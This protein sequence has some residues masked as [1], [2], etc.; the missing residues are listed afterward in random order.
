MVHE[1]K[2]RSSLLA[3]AAVAA[4]A[5][6]GEVVVV[7]PEDVVA[8]PEDTTAPPEDTTAPPEDTTAPPDVTSE[9]CID[10][11]ALS[12]FAHP[13]RD[14]NSLLPTEREG[15]IAIGAP[16]DGGVVELDDSGNVV[17]SAVP[18]AGGFLKAG[19]RTGDGGLVVV[20]QQWDTSSPSGQGLWLGRLDGAGALRAAHSLGPTHFM[21]HAD[22]ELLQHPNGG[23]VLS[24]HDSQMDGESPRLVL[25]RLDD[26]GQLV[27]RRATPLAPGSAIAAGWSRGSAAL[28][29][30][31]DVVQL[32]AHGAYL[33]IV[34]S[35]EQTEPVFD[36]VLE[37]VG[38][39]WPQDIAVLPDG[40]MAIVALSHDSLDRSHVILLDAGG[41]VLWHETYEP[42]L[43]NQ[44][45]ALAYDPSTDLL[46]LAGATRGTD[47][48][49]QRMWLLSVTTEGAL[50]WEYEGDVGTPTLM[51]TIAALPGGGFAAAGFGDFSYVVVRPD[52][53]P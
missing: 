53:C 11:V 12:L 48:G 7:P 39:A 10:G 35:T 26:D 32:T 4:L 51:N 16:D 44:L 6:C 2:V 43:D 52:A 9:A 36:R 5:G 24:T 23:Y 40:R 41:S 45:N 50:R 20:G 27:H 18:L 33:R 25:L 29:P 47:G 13:G 22:I 14:V 38:E 28:L 3:F 34:R 15:F 21:A 1:G 17:W 8:P 49:T 37:E 42:E 46:H 19:A 31:G 30:G